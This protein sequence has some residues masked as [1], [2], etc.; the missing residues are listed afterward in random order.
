LSSWK[1]AI[2][3]GPVL[4]VPWILG[5]EDQVT[6]TGSNRV[7]S[8][9]PGVLVDGV[10]GH[11]VGASRRNIRRDVVDRTPP[12]TVFQLLKPGSRELDQSGGWIALL[13]RIGRRALQGWF[14]LGRHVHAVPTAAAGLSTDA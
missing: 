5:D 2:V 9:A 13:S 1:A 14:R 6:P 10:D 12:T 7:G 3:G 4:R 11:D 8:C